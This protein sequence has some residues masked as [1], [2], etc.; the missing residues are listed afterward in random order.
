MIYA[1]NLYKSALK[2]KD[3]GVQ[4]KEI[5]LDFN[6]VLDY[7]DELVQNGIQGNEKQIALYKNID[8]IKKNGHCL[9]E[10]SVEVEN[11]VYSGSNMLIS[12]GTFPRIPPI[13]GINEI[14]YLTHENIFN[15]KKLPKSILFVG[16]GFISL[17]F[18]N[19][20]N[21]FGSKVYII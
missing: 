19:A 5:K 2:A 3:F 15:L 14:D 4:I 21:T 12:T 20:F 18:A 7:A 6:K 1:T 10:K 8:Y 9:S 11:E 13:E 16:G 17:E